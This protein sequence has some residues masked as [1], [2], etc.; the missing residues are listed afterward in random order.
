MYNQSDQET[1][2]QYEIE[3]HKQSDWE[4]ENAV[5]NTCS[6]RLGIRKGNMKCM[7]NQ[8]GKEKRQYEIHVQSDQESETAI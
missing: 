4:R 1:E 6:I 2:G 5:G 8:T 3:M 7:T